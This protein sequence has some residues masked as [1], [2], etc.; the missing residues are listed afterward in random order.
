MEKLKKGKGIIY[1][2]GCL[3]QVLSSTFTT[4]LFRDIVYI[5]TVMYKF[6]AMK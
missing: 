2:S 5:L 3:R 4:T 1:D 6:I